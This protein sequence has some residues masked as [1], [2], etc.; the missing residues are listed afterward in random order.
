[1]ISPKILKILWDTISPEQNKPHTHK[2]SALSYQNPKEGFGP[3][4]ETYAICL[5]QG[6]RFS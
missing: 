3:L 2:H 6:T 1:M 4:V 5:F